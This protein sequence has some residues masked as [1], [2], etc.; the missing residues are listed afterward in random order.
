MWKRPITNGHGWPSIKK[1]TINRS[2]FD[3]SD[4]CECASARVSYFK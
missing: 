4:E 2:G 3:M 1:K